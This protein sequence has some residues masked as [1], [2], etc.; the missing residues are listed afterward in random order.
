MAASCK[1][2]MCF[3]PS[4]EAIQVVPQKKLTQHKANMGNP[5]ELTLDETAF[6]I[7]VLTL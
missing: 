7:L 2:G 1:A 3:T 5:M 6:L 4:F